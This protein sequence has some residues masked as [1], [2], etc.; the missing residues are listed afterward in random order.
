MTNTQKSLKKSQKQLKNLNLTSALKQLSKNATNLSKI[1]SQSS[2]VA[3]QAD[4][5]TT[6]ITT[7]QSQQAE[8]DRAI[9]SGKT[10]RNS[11][12][13]QRALSSLSTHNKNLI[14][15]L[16]TLRHNIGVVSSN[17]NVIADNI[18]QV[19]DDQQSVT[20]DFD[21]VQSVL[22]TTGVALTKDS[23]NV[24]I[25]QQNLI[26]EQSYLDNLSKSGILNVL[27]M[28]SVDLRTD[29]M[30]NALSQFNES[31]NKETTISVVLNKTTASIKATSTLK[32]VQQLT[33]AT[34][35]GTS[36]SKSFLH[37]SGETVDVAKQQ[38]ALNHDLTHLVPWLIGLVILYLLIISQS[39]FAIY[40]SISLLI[41]FWGG[42]QLT[43]WFSNLLLKTPLLADVPIISG[44]IVSCLSL[45][46]L[47]PIILRTTRATTDNYLSAINFFDPLLILIGIMTL[48][49]LLALG[50]TQ[51]LSFIQIALIVFISQLVW[52]LLFPIGIT[53]ALH[54]SYDKN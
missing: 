53:A 6:D 3:N 50:F 23:K 10:S 25:A 22:K 28:T 14:S 15:D 40:A 47:I 20:D 36:L 31:N 37:Y 43:N 45:G 24:Q 4:E 44:L 54:L 38:Q 8:I 46:I 29:P 41:T 30:K 49:P 19:E 51:L 7:M 13:I 26:G 16:K 39:L 33:N 1:Q 27:Y 18:S 5:L 32:Q 52:G 2:Q 17:N 42:L 34:L 48:I 9:R 21:K 35:S 11:T 12:G